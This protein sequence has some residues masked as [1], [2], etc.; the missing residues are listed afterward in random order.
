MENKNFANRRKIKIGLKGRKVVICSYNR[1]VTF[2]VI[3][4]LNSI[5]EITKKYTIGLVI[6]QVQGRFENQNLGLS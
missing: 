1:A 5:A 2:Q 6:P 3:I 4:N